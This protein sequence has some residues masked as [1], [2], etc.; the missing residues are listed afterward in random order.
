MFF[1]AKKWK[2]IENKCLGSKI[3]ISHVLG[4]LPKPCTAMLGSFDY[5]LTTLVDVFSM[6]KNGKS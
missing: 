3:E 4:F 2:H 1:C 6:G 5:E